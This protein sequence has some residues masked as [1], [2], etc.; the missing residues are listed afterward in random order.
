[1]ILNIFLYCSLIIIDKSSL[2]SFVINFP[3]FYPEPPRLRM[4]ERASEGGRGREGPK[5]RGRTEREEGERGR[6]RAGTM[7]AVRNPKSSGNN[8]DAVRSEREGMLATGHDGGVNGRKRTD[9]ESMC[10]KRGIGEVVEGASEAGPH[11]QESEAHDLKRREAEGRLMVLESKFP[12]M[13]FQWVRRT[14]S[15]GWAVANRS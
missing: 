13:P 11:C 9:G 6:A 7:R 1:M 8:T 3:T 12:S 4:E 5:P 10:G 15:H 14:S 2:W